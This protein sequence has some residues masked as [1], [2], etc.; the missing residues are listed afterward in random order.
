[1]AASL[2]DASLT[3]DVGAS[4]RSNNPN[5]C[6]WPSAAARLAGLSAAF[7]AGTGTLA[8]LAMDK[9]P[10]TKQTDLRSEFTAPTL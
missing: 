6:L 10:K 7:V 8:Q 3:G 4:T 1:M 2:G 9:V 5:F